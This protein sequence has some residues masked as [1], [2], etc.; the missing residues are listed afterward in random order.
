MVCLLDGMADQGSM[1]LLLVYVRRSAVG[2]AGCRVDSTGG[3]LGIHAI[4]GS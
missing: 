2:S 1:C 4:T 3:Q